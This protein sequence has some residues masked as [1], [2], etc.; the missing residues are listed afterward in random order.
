MIVIKFG[1]SS[2]ESAKAIQRVTSIVRERLSQQPVVVVSAMGKTTDQLVDISR[3]AASGNPQEASRKLALLRMFHLREA[4]LLARGANA[5]GL[6]RDIEGL[7][8]DLQRILL[9][10]SESGALTPPVCD[11]ILSFGERLSSLIV[12]AAFLSV[13][14]D[15]VHLDARTAIVTDSSHGQ[16]APLFIETN[17]LLRRKVTL[18]RVT[19]IG[20]FIGATENGVTTTLGRGGSD[21]T[22]AI[23][24]A[25]LAADEIQ[26]WTDVDGILSADPR[27]V[28]AAHCLRSI[29]Y[30]EAEQLAKSGAKVLHPATVLPAVRQHIPIVIRNSRNESAPGTRITGDSGS[31]GE[32][33]V[34]SIACK[35]DMAVLHLCPRST[36]VT[37][38]F[39][40]AMWESLQESGVHFDLA[41]PPEKEFSLIVMSSAITP[42]LLRRLAHSA[43]ITIEEGRALVSLVGRNPVKNPWNVARARLCLSRSAGAAVMTCCTDSRFGFIVDQSAITEAAEAL[44]QEFFSEPDPRVYFVN[45]YEGRCVSDRHAPGLKDVRHAT[46]VHAQG[47]VQ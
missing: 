35:P 42:T 21:Y 16:A 4:A 30:R 43:D 44:H 38:E 12:T 25:A 23:V 1:G 2:V 8:T 5:I 14:S 34:L 32:G 39:G 19:V 26:I 37:P 18:D 24:G 7:I 11:A 13:G 47:G 29:S 31:A 27:I 41:L 9:E 6:D 46:P 20:G 28:S 3:L 10:V 22:A 33:I 15:A 40:R 36:P 17:A 45:R